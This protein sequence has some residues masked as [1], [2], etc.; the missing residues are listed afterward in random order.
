M[1]NSNFSFYF[2]SSNLIRKMK[3]EKKNKLKKFL[4]KALNFLVYLL[5]LFTQHKHQDT[6]VLQKIDKNGEFFS[7]LK[8][9]LRK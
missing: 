5:L 1:Q 2:I 9:S 3:L 8:L 4:Q 7:K 6:Q